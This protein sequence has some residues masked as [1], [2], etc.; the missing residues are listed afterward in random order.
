MNLKKILKAIRLN[1]SSISMILGAVIIVVVGILVVNYFKGKGATGKLPE[2]GNNQI[3]NEESQTVPGKSYT[4]VTGD[5][6]WLIAQKTYGSGYNWTDIANAN[7]L[8]NPSII[9]VGQVLSL[10][11]VEV[12]TATVPSAAV[13]GQQVSKFNVDTGSDAISGA[14]YQVVKG[15]NLWKISVRAYGDGFKWVEIARENK[16]VHPNLIHSGNVLVLPR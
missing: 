9:K 16:L 14:T 5:N 2:V 3:S 1:E 4:V 8:N 12:K 10:P 13:A 7:N 6:L 11:Q 15:D